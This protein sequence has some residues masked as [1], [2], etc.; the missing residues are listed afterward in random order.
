MLLQT[1]INCAIILTWMAET[2]QRKLFIEA[3]FESE[4]F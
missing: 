2:I 4:G 1:P 3:V